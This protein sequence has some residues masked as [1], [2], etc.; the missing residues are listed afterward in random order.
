MR[1]ILCYAVVL[2]IVS[3]LVTTPQAEEKRD[4]SKILENLRK[5]RLE[6]IEQ[7]KKENL[8]LKT[9][10]FLGDSLTEGFDLKKFFPELKAVNR[11]IVADH[12][13]VQGKDGV[14]QRLDNSVF[15]CNP[16]RVVLMIGVNDIGDD[17]HNPELM[18]QGFREI[19]ET[20]RKHDPRITV[21]VQ[22]CL[23]TGG[24]YARLNPM[25]VE[26][27]KSIESIAEETLSVYVNV[28]PLFADEKG[29]LIP[30]LTREGLHL[31]PRGYEV[32]AA[33]LRK[34]LD[35]PS[36]ELP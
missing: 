19:I 36:P 21:Y 14:L 13:G 12:I 10:V 35:I 18:A 1:Q 24:K 7:F 30:E 16:T 20:I 25:I 26:F 33:E 11:G 34:V 15:D 8:E 3:G 17:D 2:I 27:N 22:S 5:H 32:W 4:I 9:T 31:T 6:R 28:H 23:P 29:E